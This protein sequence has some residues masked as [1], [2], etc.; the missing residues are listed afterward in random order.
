MTGHPLELQRQAP[1]TKGLISYVV[2]TDADL[3]PVINSF[4]AQKQM[5]ESALP[6]IR[7]MY[8]VCGRRTTYN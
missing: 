8:G 5:S 2:V 1:T 4:V 7:Q 3:H 6:L